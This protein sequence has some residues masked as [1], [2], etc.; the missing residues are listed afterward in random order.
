MSEPGNQTHS[1]PLLSNAL[2]CLRPS[3]CHALHFLHPSN[4]PLM[5]VL[6]LSEKTVGEGRLGA[7]SEE[8]LLLVGV[9][10][11][12]EA[13]VGESENFLI[14]TNT[15]TVKSAFLSE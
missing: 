10:V 5:R 4:F 8:C 1:V 9:E 15:K 14:T 11:V 7:P 6:T 2:A 3:N 12:V 13:W